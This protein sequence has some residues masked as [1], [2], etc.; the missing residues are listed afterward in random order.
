MFHYRWSL[1]S[2]V[3]V[4]LLFSGMLKLNYAESRSIDNLSIHLDHIVKGSLQPRVIIGLV[5]GAGLA[6]LL[7]L[8]IVL[9]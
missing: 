4:V 5:L 8:S 1:L 7:N 6:V 9:L 2:Q 3:L